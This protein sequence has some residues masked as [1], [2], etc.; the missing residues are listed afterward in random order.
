MMIEELKLLKYT[1]LIFRDPCKKCLVR[2]CCT[3]HCKKKQDL[4]HFVGE[5]TL[6]AKRWV[7]ILLWVNVI[8]FPLLMWFAWR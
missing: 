4:D 1:I 5:D 8:Y 7:A 6:K 2:A 3:Q